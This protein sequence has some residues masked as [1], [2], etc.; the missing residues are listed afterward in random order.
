MIDACALAFAT[1]HPDKTEGLVIREHRRCLEVGGHPPRAGDHDQH[2]HDH[3]DCLDSLVHGCSRSI[4]A[5]VSSLEACAA[6]GPP[7]PCP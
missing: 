7:R 6:G 3:Q 4:P 5:V 1:D 2:R